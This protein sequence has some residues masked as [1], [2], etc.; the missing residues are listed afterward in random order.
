MEP[1]CETHSTWRSVRVAVVSVAILVTASCGSDDGTDGGT[2]GG[3]SERATDPVQVAADPDVTTTAPFFTVEDVPDDL[4]PAAA[5][6]GTRVQEWGEDSTGTNQPLTVLSPPGGAPDEQVVVLVTGYEGYQG[7]LSQAAYG[8]PSEDHE[9]FEVDGRPAL[10]STSSARK[11]Q[12]QLL[13]DRGGDLA[14]EVQGPDDRDLLLAIDRA[15]EPN[16][17]ATAP[18]VEDPPAGLAVVGHLDASAVQAV[19]C[20]FANDNGGEGPLGSFRA[21]WTDA[22]GATLSVIG[23]PGADGDLVGFAGLAGERTSVEHSVAGDRPAMLIETRYDDGETYAR[24]VAFHD[25][26]GNLFVVSAYS[27]AGTAP[28]D[29]ATLTRVGATIELTDRGGWKRFVEELIGLD[30][31]EVTKGAIELERGEVAGVPWLLETGLDGL[32]GPELAGPVASP[33]LRLPRRQT[34]CAY[35]TSGMNS[36]AGTTAIGSFQEGYDPGGAVGPPFPGFVTVTTTVPQASLRVTTSEGVVTRPLHPI[37]GEPARSGGVVVA[38]PGGSFRCGD[39]AAPVPTPP[40]GVTTAELLDGA[41]A[42]VTC[43][44]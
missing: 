17:R 29:E 44:S 21:A 19:C 32:S 8:Y 2:D 7:G 23:L 43:L 5:G 1:H 10:L 26:V 16:G 22:S 18:S 4:T 25:R 36:P 28:A 31:P 38:A 3:S 30:V 24:A 15:T 14:V 41:G 33:C 20:A 35:G 6:P 9:E 39:P 27:G 13:V 12:A 42:V 11:G 37:P 34:R 40:P